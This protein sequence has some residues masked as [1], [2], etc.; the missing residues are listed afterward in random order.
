MIALRTLREFWRSHPD[1]VEPLQA[2]HDGVRSRQWK[3]AAD[4]ISQFPN[5][6]VLNDRRLAF[7]I[8]GNK[9]RLIVKVHYRTKSVFVRYIGTHAEY[10]RIDVNR[11]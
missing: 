11:V 3:S 4:A 5:V 9:Y 10:D 7:N 1:A 8:A 2:W 6:S